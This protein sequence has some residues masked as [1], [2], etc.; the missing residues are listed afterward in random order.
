MAYDEKLIA[1]L[2]SRAKTLRRDTIE[3]IKA[4]VLENPHVDAIMALHCWPELE[5][6]QV[7]VAS[8][9][10]MAGALA[11]QVKLTGQQAHAGAR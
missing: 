5:A 2:E 9:P 4:G 1:A 3:M 6:G 8:G 10:S 11:F 7:G